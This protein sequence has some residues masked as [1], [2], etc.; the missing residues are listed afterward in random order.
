M[1]DASPSRPKLRWGAIVAAALAVAVGASAWLIDSRVGPR[2]QAAGSPQGFVTGAWFCPHGGSTGWRAWI[3]VA[4][5]GD[6]PVAV[7]VTSFTASGPG[8]SASFS[9]GAGRQ[10][11]REVAATDPSAST[12]VEYFGGIVGASAVIQA[13]PT[14]GVAAEGCSIGPHR[15]W[16][17]PDERTSVGETAYV[18]VMNPFAQ[19]ASFDVVIRSEDREVRP[20]ALTP[21][22]LGPRAS[23]GIRVNDYALLAEGE[24]TVA[25]E[26]VPRSGRVIAGGT[27]STAT[28]L[29]AEMGLDSASGEWI[30]PAAGY[31]G[32]TEIV[33]MDLGLSTAEMSVD[34]QSATASRLVSGPVGLSVP[35]GG[36]ATFQVDGLPDAGALVRSTNGVPVAL[37]LRLTGENGDVATLFGAPEAAASWLAMATVPPNG[38]TQSLVLENPGPTDSIVTFTLIGA[39]AA[40]PLAPVTVPAGRT[41]QVALG[42][43]VGKRGV[44]VLVRSQAGGIVV[45][46]MSSSAGGTGYAVTLAIPI[47]N[48]G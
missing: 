19:D 39:A 26:V 10:V 16:L 28:G 9:V 22:A 43:A 7:R 13:G 1:V 14:G 8:D 32:S 40:P 24:D 48:I 29:R 12:E 36:V 41:I 27:V 46:S 2:A 11:Y 30:V 34:S 37:A 23:V 21:F 3:V 45:A 20:T 35:A 42:P 44:S 5:P 38:G 25:V 47:K 33:A 6:E 31:Q 4:N 17:L 18:V 15:D